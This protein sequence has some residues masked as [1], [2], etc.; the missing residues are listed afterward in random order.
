MQAFGRMRLDIDN[1]VRELVDFGVVR[2]D[3]GP[4][5]TYTAHR[6]DGPAAACSTSSWSGG[7]MSASR[8]H[9]PRSSA[10]AR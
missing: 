10:S 7:L 9:R 3:A 1:C 5:P 6:P 8:S 2:K 4:T